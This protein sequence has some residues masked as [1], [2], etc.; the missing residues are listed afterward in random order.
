MAIDELEH[1]LCSMSR[2]GGGG[3]GGFEDPTT[4]HKV[5]K[6]PPTVHTSNITIFIYPT[7]YPLE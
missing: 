7:L 3:Y 5:N 4:V 1:D 2:G 6:L